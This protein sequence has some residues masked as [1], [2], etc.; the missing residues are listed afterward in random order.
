M[1]EVGG[2]VEEFDVDESGEEEGGAEAVAVAE[3]DA[4]GEDGEGGEVGVHSPLG[5]GLDPAEAGVGEVVGW[6]DVELVDP[7]V[8]EEAG[9]DEEGGEAEGDAEGGEGCGVGRG[10]AEG[11]GVNVRGQVWVCVVVGVGVTWAELIVHLHPNPSK[12]QCR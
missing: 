8:G 9:D 12:R 6:L 7:A 10:A 4:D 2:F 1:V 5:P 3:G 11:K